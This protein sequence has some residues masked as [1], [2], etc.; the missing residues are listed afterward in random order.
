VIL[1]NS[2][3]EKWTAGGVVMLGIEVQLVA[4]G[5]RLSLNDLADLLAEKVATRIT[6]A[7][8]RAV[9]PQQTVGNGEP[10]VVSVPDAAKLLGL[11]RSTVWRY[12]QVKV[13]EIEYYVEKRPVLNA[14]NCGGRI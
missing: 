2:L 4:D 14:F 13:R 11:S 9:Q 3:K 6:F 10:K 12:I 5:R 7:K 1:R 8:E